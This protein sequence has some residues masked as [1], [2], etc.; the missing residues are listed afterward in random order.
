MDRYQVTKVVGK[1][2]FG[3]ALL[4]RSRKDGR[5]CIIKQVNGTALQHFVLLS[6]TARGTSTAS[7][8]SQAAWHAPQA[9]PWD[10]CEVFA[11]Q[12]DTAKLGP[13]ERR[14]AHKEAALLATMRH[15]NI[16]GELPSHSIAVCM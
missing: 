11:K 14:K 4:C 16:V 6:A 10:A 5:L 7:L 15:P 1:G 12:V 3:K 13:R 2:S 9:L 8:Q